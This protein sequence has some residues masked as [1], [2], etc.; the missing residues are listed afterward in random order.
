MSGCQTHLAV[1]VLQHDGHLQLHLIAFEVFLSGIYDII[2]K[3]NAL[4]CPARFDYFFHNSGSFLPASLM[5]T[6]FYKS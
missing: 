4:S 3:V 2:N 1:S 6:S 5:L